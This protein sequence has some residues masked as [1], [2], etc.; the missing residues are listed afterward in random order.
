MN[1]CKEFIDKLSEYIDNELPH[2]ESAIVKGHIESC[3]S[4]QDEFNV[5]QTVKHALKSLPQKTASDEVRERILGRV[6]PSPRRALR[7]RSG[8]AWERGEWRRSVLP[9]SRTGVSPVSMAYRGLALAASILLFIFVTISDTTSSPVKAYV[10]EH[11]RCISEGH[12]DYL[13]KTEHELNQKIENTMGVKAFIPSYF[14]EGFKFI[15]GDVCKI[16][17]IT[18]AHMIMGKGEKMLSYFQAKGEITSEG[19]MQ[20]GKLENFNYA[21]WKKDGVYCIVVGD[22]DEKEIE[23]IAS[24]Q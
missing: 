1:K 5:L 11:Q 15:K 23:R 2:A 20:A 14:P 8:Q 12:R 7:L 22:V 4:C 21:Y 24:S 6:Y 9:W 18:A 13:C 19:G 16:K 10:L 3:K 17:G